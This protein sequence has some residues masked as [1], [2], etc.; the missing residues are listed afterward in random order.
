MKKNSLTES[1]RNGCRFCTQPD[2]DRILYRTEN[3]YVMVSLGAFI[4][5]YL[6]IISKH[7]IGAS[8]NIPQ[9]LFEE[10]LSLKNKVHNILCQEYGA[11]IFYEHGKSGSSLTNKYT[12]KHCYHA[13]IHCL[14]ISIALN[15]IVSN[16]FKAIFYNSLQDAAINNSHKK[17]LYIE[18]SNGIGIYPSRINLR[19]Q[20]LR[21]QVCLA[22]DLNDEWDWTKYQNKTNIAKTINKLQP[23]FL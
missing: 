10:F 23:L 2:Q 5:G 17:Y 13:H 22:L 7:H 8:L 15:K 11:C 16:D 12:N 18:D 4:E 1:I 14:P 9:N 3:F 21:Y 20:Y 19:K 6:L